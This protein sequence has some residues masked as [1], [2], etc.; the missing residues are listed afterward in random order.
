MRRPASTT[1]R[2]TALAV[3][4]ALLQCAIPL[5]ADA[6]PLKFPKFD[7][8]ATGIE[9]V[10]S[11]QAADNSVRLVQD[12]PTYVRVYATHE[13]DKPLVFNPL[14]KTRLSAQRTAPGPVTPLGTLDAL[15]FVPDQPSL[16]RLSLGNSA[17]FAIPKSWR[18]GTVQ[19]T[20]V[21]DVEDKYVETSAANNTV[22]TTVTFEEV[23][24]VRLRVYSMDTPSGGLPTVADL[25]LLGSWLRRAFPT[26]ALDVEYRT[27]ASTVNVG[28]DACNCPRL[29]TNQMTPSTCQNAPMGACFSDLGCGMF[30]PC[31]CAKGDCEAVGTCANAPGRPC[32]SGLDCGCGRVNDWL[33]AQRTLDQT[34]DPNF[35]PD[36]RY[37][38][39][40][41]DSGGFMR[42]CSPGVDR[43]VA[44]G[45]T[46]DPVGTSFDWDTDASYGDFYTG[47]ELGHAY[48]LG[49]WTCC[50]A[51]DDAPKVPYPMCALGQGG[52]HVA[53]DVAGPTL[54]F[55]NQYT[56]LMAYCDFQ[57]TSD[58]TYHDIMD[59]LQL[60]GGAP[61]P[62]PGPATDKL[63][64]QGSANL[65]LGT[66][67]IGQ[68]LQL[69]AFRSPVTGAGSAG[70]YELRLVDGS[71]GS[72]SHFFTPD[73][74]FDD[75]EFGPDDDIAST[76]R[77]ASFAELVPLPPGPILQV[78]LRRA[79]T[80]LDSR[81]VSAT[82]PTVTLTF[83]N[84]GETLTAVPTVVTWSAADADGDPLLSTLLYSTDGGVQWSA[85][86]TE[87]EAS[88]QAID[89]TTLPGS[90]QVLFRVLVSD[91]FHTASDD[92][93]A[94]LTI[95]D[96]APRVQVTSPLGGAARTEREAIVF[97]ALASDPEDGMLAGTALTWSSDRQ[98]PL[99]TG[100]SLLV[101][102][103]APG[104]HVVTVEAT[105]S[106]GHTVADS[107]TILVGAATADA[108][109]AVPRTGCDEMAVQ[110]TAYRDGKNLDKRKLGVKLARSAANHVQA[111][112]GTP[113]AGTTHALCVYESNALLVALVL[114]DTTWTA[115]GSRGYK[116]KADGT[117]ATLRAGTASQPA[118]A[119][120]I[121]KAKGTAVPDV[122]PPVDV[123]LT[124]QLVNDTN[125]TC[126]EGRWE[127]LAKNEV[128]FLKG[129]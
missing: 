106:A 69:P 21:V 75:R 57:W 100:E 83:P 9:V 93:D 86:A 61:V 30:G 121:V 64:I 33:T 90:G 5:E 7:I 3:L 16:P 55:G 125:A 45:P 24:P 48:G 99:G 70:D 129:R 39:I 111:D 49:H 117:R 78:E 109:P 44:S 60:E 4:V 96:A 27:V 91:G 105:D 101:P 87:I 10:Q 103:L 123:P 80:L 115:A 47:H 32:D 50:G 54:Y 79:G 19:F 34:L 112:F 118:P 116:L 58:V 84:G 53:L 119:T 20:A 46:G 11:I 23:P 88:S 128:N 38:A 67:R 110:E 51:T 43:K 2:T 37:V 36:R 29:C 124:M 6:L 85:L 97:E 28:N 62:P 52:T 56:D 63:F 35:A 98:G 113:G 107:V 104:T 8:T 1:R 41:H 76:E 127:S 42:G 15:A 71:G 94:V 65:G 40:V 18:S 59:R 31:Q 108:C 122:D 66:A 81:T 102:Q 89:P 26:P 13:S 68:V 72:T 120:L 73:E 25:S 17:N 95:P 92:S 126:F 12:K 114:P 82:A 74:Y 14:V 77:I 22:V